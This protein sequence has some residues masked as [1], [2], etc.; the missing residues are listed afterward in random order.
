MMRRNIAANVVARAWSIIAAYV[1]VPV[2]LR[3]MGIEAYGL[4]GFY[5]TLVAVLT[6]ADMGFTATLN[7]ELVRLSVRN[8]SASEMGVLLRTYEVLYLFISASVA[9]A[10]WFSGPWIAQRWLHSNTLP[11]PEVARAIQLMGVGIAFQ[12][13]ADLYTGGLIGLQR[14]VLSSS[15]QISWSMSRACG[16]IL[17]LWLWSPTVLAFSTWQLVCNLLFCLL[18]R[19]NLWRVILRD[20][21]VSR[22]TFSWSMLQ[23]TWRYAVG[24]AGMAVMMTLL[25]Q[26]DKAAVSK[27]LPLDILGYYTIASALG[28]SPSM[29]GAPIAAAVFPRLA[30][31]AATEARIE[32][33]RVYHSACQLVVVVAVSGGLTLAAY[34]P[35]FIRAWTGSSLTA[36]YAGIAASL[37]ILGQLMQVI[38]VVPTY[39]SLAYGNVRLN[40]QLCLASVVIVIPLLILLIEKYGINGAGAAW[41]IMNFTVVLPFTFVTHRRYLPGHFAKWLSR[42]IALPTLGALFG[43]GVCR[44]LIPIPS[45]RPL[46]LALIACA[47]IFSAACAACLSSELRSRLWSSR[48][49]VM[50]LMSSW[51]RVVSPEQ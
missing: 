14:Q 24:M 39:L 4:V 42:D 3:F 19:W 30:G 27:L 40:L 31:L 23:K 18:I 37:L 21:R 29:L 12:L 7:R 22:F 17:V 41:L 15:L 13:P 50:N 10:V 43:V 20:D 38:M 34:A 49:E 26:S 25:T 2:Y 46:L 47:W 5:A 33:Q 1:F 45:A 6:F 32:F 9:T 16:A 8:D 35:E 51:S 44:W 11:L 48:H 28:T 36:Q